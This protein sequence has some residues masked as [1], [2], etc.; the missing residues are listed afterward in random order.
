MQ[1]LQERVRELIIDVPNF[2]IEGI[3]F[4]DIL[5]LFRHPE[6][7]KGVV[8]EMARELLPYQPT[9]LAGMESRGFLLGLP[10]ALELNIP[11][12]CI[13]KKGKLPGEVSGIAYS[14]E[15]G[16]AEIEMQKAALNARDRVILH[17]DV[18]ATGGTANAAAQLIQSSRAELVAFSFLME[19]N[20]LKGREIIGLNNAPVHTF[21]QF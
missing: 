18:L 15:Y 20:F 11:F 1:T 8:S 5:P 16:R 9:V 3:V 14:L 13:R 19:L 10:L 6:L 12:V 21:A 4:K 2:P 17:D 7:I